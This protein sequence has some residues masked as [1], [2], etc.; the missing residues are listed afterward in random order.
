[1]QAVGKCEFKHRAPVLQLARNP[2]IPGGRQESE[3]RS[4]CIVEA[5]FRTFGIRHAFPDD[6]F[7][8]F[9]LGNAVLVGAD[10]ARRPRFD[11]ALQELPDLPVNL[12]QA[13]AE[14]PGLRLRLLADMVPPFAQHAARDAKQV[15]TRLQLFQKV[16]E[17][18]FDPVPPDRLAVAVTVGRVLSG[19]VRIL[20]ATGG[21]K[22]WYHPTFWSYLWTGMIKGVW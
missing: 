15:F 11:H 17:L 14:R 16:F 12:G 5:A 13:F 20:P 22:Q 7:L 10:D 21:S 6:Q 9:Q 1:M 18:A 2:L 4:K 8:L 3:R 19:D